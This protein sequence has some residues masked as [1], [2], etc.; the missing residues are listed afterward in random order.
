MKKSTKEVVGRVKGKEQ[1][2]ELKS[3]DEHDELKKFKTGDL[4]SNYTVK[5]DEVVFNVLSSDTNT[6]N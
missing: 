6:A 3:Y 5:Q 2:G 1:V 4:C